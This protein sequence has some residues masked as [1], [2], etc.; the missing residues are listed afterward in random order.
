[1]EQGTLIGNPIAIGGIPLPSDAPLF[2]AFIA[3]HVAAGLVCVISGV[4][5]MLSQKRAGRHP[6]FGT[7][8]YWALVLVFIT[9]TALSL[10]RWA[11]DYQL[12]VLGALSFIAATA[13]R[14]ARRRLWPSWARLHMTGMGASYILLLTAFYVDNGKNL[15]LWRELPHIAFWLLPGAIGAPIL[16]NAFLRHPLVR[17]SPQTERR[18]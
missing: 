10:A 17:H 15:P 11:E 4:V 1:M 12:F 2:L 3:L 6:R 18:R 8:Y 13:G 5:A 14:M 7:I 9:M 16:L